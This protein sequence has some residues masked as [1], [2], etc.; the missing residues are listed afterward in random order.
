MSEIKKNNVIYVNPEEVREK[1][2]DP[3]KERRAELANKKKLTIRAVIIGVVILVGLAFLI[4]LRKFKGYKVLETTPTDYE[5]TANYVEFSG[6]LLKYTS[7]GV[8]Y[9]NKNCDTVWTAGINMDSPIVAV[10]DNYAVVAN[11]G[12]NVVGVFN[13]NGQISS[14]T[15]PY[16]ILDVDV[17]NQ[18]AFTV[19]LESSKTNYINI[20][21]KNGEI[22]CEMQATID[23]NGY[24]LDVAI[25]DD[26]QKILVS[27]L[28]V[29]GT[30]VSN[31]IAGYN[32][33]NVGQNANADRLVGE[34]VF[35]DEMFPKLEFIDKNVAVAYGSSSIYIYKMKEKP[36]EQARIKLD[37]E[38]TSV[39][40]HNKYIG[41]VEKNPDSEKHPYK[42]T[43]YSLKGKKKMDKYI[44]F[45]YNRVFASKDE[46]VVTGED[47]MMVIRKNGSVKF[48]KE[49]RG[50]VLLAVPTGKKNEYI[51][52]YPN[53]I[54]IIRLK[55]DSGVSGIEDE[56]ITEDQFESDYFRIEEVASPS[57]A[58]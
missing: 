23:K 16:K 33:G 40:Y 13:E 51:V 21:D 19:I 25:S 36:V 42:L 9:L 57:D 52:S 8:S 20:Y 11:Q 26:G 38:V 48:N 41:V 1:K 29:N 5:N 49:M 17:A 2:K 10:C 55:I 22:I 47:R 44:D 58:I 14:V 54:D 3:N 45:N 24:P 4:K 30:K 28:K 53:A 27:H 31:V 56:K 35:D 34:F 6:G 37:N 50:D 7:A 18:G 46:I 32:F 15:M 39:F 43:T 12:G